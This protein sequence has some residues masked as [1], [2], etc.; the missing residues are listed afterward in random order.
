[1]TYTGGFQD[2]GGP[3]L[4]TMSILG[5]R[6]RAW[7]A[8]SVPASVAWPV[9]NDAYLIPF[10][11]SGPDTFNEMFF[12]AGT[13]PGTANFDLGVYRENFTRIAS[14]GATAAVNTTDALLPA[15]GGAFST[16]ITLP[17]G[18]YYMAMSAAAIT[19]TCRAAV[20]TNEF[21]RAIGMQKMAAAHP[22]PATITP[23]SM[24][25]TAFIPT[26]GLSWITNIL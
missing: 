26:L 7:Q 9:A 11:L 18:R 8:A 19:I 3:I 21:C 1:M 20:P 17:P 5:S 25:T 12:I 24:G 13:T 4:T 6:R 14:L 15:G 10:E 16:P 23:A 22:L 2:R